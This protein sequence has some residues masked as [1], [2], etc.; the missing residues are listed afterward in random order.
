M[1]SQR[2]IAGQPPAAT[3]R[4]LTV[5][6]AASL[7][8][9]FDDLGKQFESAHTGVKVLLNYAGSQQLSAQLVQGA[10]ADVFASAN[11]KEMQTA[12]NG[13]IVI[14]GTQMVFARN[15]L[16]I[17]FPKDNPG[18][19]NTLADLA[20][21]GLKL[22]LA[23]KSV[24]AGQY[25]LDMLAK[26]SKDP[27]YGAS[28]A[29]RV[30]ENVVSYETDVKAVVSKVRLGEVDAGVVYATDANAA[31]DELASLAIPAQ[32]NQIATYPIAPTARAL[33]PDL[34][35]QFVAFVLSPTGQQTLA[36]YG[37]IGRP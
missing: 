37:F 19:I 14:S 25:S 33:Q 23:D 34:A 36:R 27:G 5:F 35:V 15:R 26:M 13:G 9:S 10:A 4:T 31:A 21:P 3:P 16:V 12:I 7:S 32:F 24:P 2:P 20:R 30:L 8:E 1:A 18:K 17:I 6:A 29:A 28:F 11:T 22:D